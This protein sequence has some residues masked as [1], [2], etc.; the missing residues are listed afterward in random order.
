M[1]KKRKL[2]PSAGIHQANDDKRKDVIQTSK[3]PDFPSL[4][5]QL[6]VAAPKAS[7]DTDTDGWIRITPTFS[8]RLLRFG[9]AYLQGFVFAFIALACLYL[10]DFTFDYAHREGNFVRFFAGFFFAAVVLVAVCAAINTLIRD[11]VCHIHPESGRLVCASQLTKSA[12]HDCIDLR[13]VPVLEILPPGTFIRRTRII[14]VHHNMEANVMDT[15]G[16]DE[17]VQALYSWMREVREISSSD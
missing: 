15:S 4:G 12:I 11:T 5:H 13:T 6:Q 9:M 7:K 2:K 14:T 16:K 10:P 17:D 3:M 8:Q 1:K